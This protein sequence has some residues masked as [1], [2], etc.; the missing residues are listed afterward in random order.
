MFTNTT[1]QSKRTR[2]HPGPL[3]HTLILLVLGSAFII[4]V[5]LVQPFYSINLWLSDQLFISEPPSPNIVV[6]GIDDDTLATYGKWS[7]WPRS[8]HTQAINSLNQAGA[9]V[10]ALDILFA[11][12]TPDDEM[13]A[14]AIESAGNVVLPFV[15]T[16]PQ[17]SKYSN[18]TYTHLL[19]PAFLLEQAS[20]NLGHGN[21]MPDPDGRVRHLPLVIKDNG[22]Q[23]YPAFSLAILH[24]LFSAPFPSQ[25]PREDGRLTL[26]NRSIPVDASCL[27]RI[28]FAPENTRRPYISYGDA[29]S[30]NFDPLMVEN[31][32]VLI[33]MVATGELDKWLVPN[34]SSKVPGVFIHATT[35][36]NILSQQ[37]LSETGLKTTLMILLLIMSITAF[38]LPRFGLRWGAVIVGFLFAG[39]LAGSFIAFENGYILNILYPLLILPF[40][41]GSSSLAK[42]VAM[43][44]ENTKLNLEVLEGYK[45]T[46]RALAAAIDAKDHYTRGHSQRVTELALIGVTSLK[47]S[48]EERE[49]LEYAAILHDIGKIGISD[50]ILSKTGQLTLKEF[51]VIRQHPR[52][53]ANIMEGILFLEDASKLVLHH[54]E[55]YD[56]AGYPDGLIGEDI[57]LGARLLAVVDSFD[58]MTSD[59]SYRV[60]IS[61][62]AAIKE[63]YKHCGTQFC[64]IAVEAFVSGYMADIHDKSSG[65]QG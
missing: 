57:P 1:S 16:E 15:G 54:H 12:S 59:R 52:I 17:M 48:S 33:G 8:L 19:S 9:K 50:S 44:I 64:P 41:Y 3:Y 20:A 43:A 42:N 62:E 47:M 21:I 63:L 60:A 14:S 56:G 49:V 18:I 24:T 5:T 6:V 39:Y 25:Y 55:R 51:D 38:C 29:I 7:S 53:G 4:F 40:M 27:Y 2:Q 65:Q 23:T 46:I 61:T 34:S 10:I 37:F 30:G 13:L 11:D 28:N 36:D 45:S 31:K 35:V 32:I 22:G 26:L 58:S